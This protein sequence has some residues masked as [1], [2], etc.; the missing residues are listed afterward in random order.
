M[1]N[2]YAGG[3]VLVKDGGGLGPNGFLDD[4]VEWHE[5]YK[6]ATGRFSYK[7]RMGIILSIPVVVFAFFSIGFH[8][9]NSNHEM[10]SFLFI[11]AYLLSIAL[12]MTILGCSVVASERS[13][14][15]LEV[16]LTTAVSARDIVKQKMRKGRTY[17][18]IFAFPITIMSYLLYSGTYY[19]YYHNEQPIMILI[20]LAT[21]F[22]VYLPLI[23]WFS[24]WVGLRVKKHGRAIVISITSV[25]LWII[26]PPLI[27]LILQPRFFAPF[28]NPKRYNLD[29]LLDLSPAYPLSQ[30][31]W[32][33]GGSTVFLTASF[34]ISTSALLILYFYFKYKCHRD[35]DKYLRGR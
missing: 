20:V 24:C 29:F 1:N 26:G 22:L 35:A 13:G 32:N 12:F 5:K 28:V 19:R 21:L 14:Q 17:I 8:D 11:A 15:R 10:Y 3:I 18:W 16:L 2:L 27:Y 7:I 25:I 31:L 34:Y 30:I 23:S 4:P 33:N 6:S 9:G